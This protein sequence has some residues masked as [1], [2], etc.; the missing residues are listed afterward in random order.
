[1]TNEIPIVCLVTYRDLGLLLVVV[2]W[3]GVF[4]VVGGLT[5]KS[6]NSELWA[7]QTGRFQT[8]NP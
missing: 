6:A 7:K 8:P 5:E 4:E 1:M 3:D 2:R